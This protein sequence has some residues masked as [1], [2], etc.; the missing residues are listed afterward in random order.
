MGLSSSSSTSTSGPSAQ[1][2]PYLTAGSGALQ[3]AY[4]ASQP[5]AQAITSGLGSAFS[6][7]LASSQNNPTT[8]AANTYDQGLLGGSYTPSPYLNGQ[9]AD[10]NNTVGNAVN[11]EFSMAGQDGSS[12][13]QG[14]VARQLATADNNL[15][16]TDYQAWLQRQQA[17]ATNATQLGALGNNTASTL[18]SL[19]VQATTQP[20]LGA[21]MYA[22]GLG[23]LWGNSQTTTQTQSPSFGSILGSLLQSGAKAASSFGGG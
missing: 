11:S 15:K 19:G 9:I 17:A 21:N 2:L 10:T 13:Q 22:S 18:G 16:S 4:N 3:S 1:A 7:L 14:E 20:M 5:N 8:A 12:R 23:S 6:N